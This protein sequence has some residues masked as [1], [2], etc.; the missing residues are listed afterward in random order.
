MN[1]E[2]FPFQLSFQNHRIAL[3]KLEVAGEASVLLIIAAWHAEGNAAAADPQEGD[4]QEDEED[5]PGHATR[6]RDDLS[7]ASGSAGRA[8]DE[9]RIHRPVKWSRDIAFYLCDV[10]FTR[11]ESH[12]FSV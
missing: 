4:V 12:K 7:H 8:R 9:T 1:S 2:R 6:G 11:R 5:N 3:S 10:I